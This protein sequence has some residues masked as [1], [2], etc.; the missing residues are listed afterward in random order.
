VQPTQGVS[1]ARRTAR[2]TVTL[3]IYSH[4]FKARCLQSP[5]ATAEL[6]RERLFTRIT[7]PVAAQSALNGTMDAT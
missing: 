6:P 3:L 2:V 7:L 1:G 4:R 5:Y